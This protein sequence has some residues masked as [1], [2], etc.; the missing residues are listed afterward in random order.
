MTSR[1]ENY[2]KINAFAFTNTMKRFTVSIPRELKE[3][4]DKM[5]EINWPEVAKQGILK[6]LDK[7]E[8]FQKLE[9][10]GKI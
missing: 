3:R 9:N 10:E 2:L 8:K 6:K 5:P 7:L 4:I 1:T